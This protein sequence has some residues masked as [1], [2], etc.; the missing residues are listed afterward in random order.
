MKEKMMMMKIMIK[1]KMKYKEIN[2]K[3]KE[4]TVQIIQKTRQLT[5]QLKWKGFKKMKKMMMIFKIKN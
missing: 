3:K 1:I 4:K 5:K 2:K